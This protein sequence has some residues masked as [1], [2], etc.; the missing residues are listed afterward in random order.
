MPRPRRNPLALRTP[1]I[2]NVLKAPALRYRDFRFLWLSTFL[3]SI[4]MMG[5]RVV[6]GWLVLEL[7][8]SALMVGVAMALGT[9]P[10]FFLGI[11]G[12]AVADRVDRRHL[13]RLLNV[14]MAANAAGVGLL[15][16]FGVVEVWHILLLTFVGGSLRALAQPA[17]QS[18]AYDIVGPGNVVN[19]LA[20]VAL[21]MRVGGLIGSLL[22]GFVLGR[23]GTAV[24]YMVVAG[25]SLMA[26]IALLPIRSRGQ[27]A[28]ALGPSVWENLKGYFREVPRNPTLL[29]LVTLTAA[30]E[31]LGFSHGVLLPSLARDVLKVGPEGLGIMTAFCSVGGILGIVLISGLGEVRRK[32]PLLIGVLHVF[33]ASIALLALA[34]NLVLVLVILAVVNAMAALSDI[35]SQ[36]LMQ[37]AV[38]NE[39]RGRAMGSWVLAVGMG[40]LGHMGIGGLASALSVAFALTSSGLGLVALAVAAAVLFPRLRRL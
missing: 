21:G 3:N 4:G 18:F 11:V 7:T 35:L 38:P 16:L 8:D 40:P 32:G 24:V 33:G 39:L 37:L 5:E 19:G 31:V 34:S 15:V 25:G 14:G 6:L 22:A 1:R 29:M 20:F 26:A 17:R 28:P 13:I 23:L 36:S 10:F 12:G 27:S 9:A 30:V 2:S